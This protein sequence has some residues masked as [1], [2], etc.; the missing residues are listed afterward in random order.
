MS[1]STFNIGLSISDRA[2]SLSSL[3]DFLELLDDQGQLVDWPD[4]VMPEPGIRNIAVAAARDAACAPAIMFQNM[5]G[6]ANKR[7]VLGVHGSW[8]NMAILLGRSKETTIRELFF[9]VTRRWGRG[10]ARIHRVP[11]DK[12]AV[13]ECRVEQNINLFNLLPLY[14]INEQDGGFYIAKAAVASRDPLD[15]ENFGKQNVGI[16]RLQLHGPNRFTLLTIPSHDM[17]R[18]IMAAETEGK[19]LKISVMIGNHPGL[20]LFAGTPVGYDESEYEYA[21][22]MMGCSLTLTESGNGVDVL[23]NSEF[24]IEAEM[25]RGERQ[26]EGP[27]GEFPGSYSGLRRAPVF[28]VTAVSHRRDPIFENIY[29][30]RGWTEH[31]TLIGLNTSAPIFAKLRESFPE[32]T[33]VN[34]LYQHGLTAIISVR[35]RMAGF[36]KSVAF[37]ALGTPHGVMYL[38]NLILVDADVDPFD[39]NQVMWALSTRTRADDIIVIPNTAM[40]PVDPS[41]ITPG[42]GHHLIIDATSYAHPDFIGE[43]EMVNPPAGDEIDALVG[44]LAALKSGR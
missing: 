33:A 44:R 2:K 17:G 37:G 25:I 42:K 15:P 40:V 36:A 18:Q 41:A 26:V 3:R 20:T 38:K 1:D 32:V 23:A 24:V 6:Y 19:A 22:S 9:E 43:A 39:L 16:Y 11:F 34:A 35:N 30:G 14:R 27:F 21:S 7:M 4:P 28:Q 13:N 5:V 12:A 10:G 29:I 8:T 31:D